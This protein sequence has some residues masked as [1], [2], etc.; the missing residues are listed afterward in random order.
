MLLIWIVFVAPNN[1]AAYEV[2]IGATLLLAVGIL[3]DKGLLHH[4]LKLFVAM[5]LAAF[6]VLWSGRRMQVF[7]QLFGEDAGWIADTTLSFV[8]V[9]GVTAAFSILDHMDGLCA[10]VCAIGSA[11]LFIWATSAGQAAEAVL[12]AGLMGA[13]LGFLWWNFHPAKIFM[14]DGGAMFL[15]FLLAA[16]SLRVEFAGMP[17]KS[18]WMTPTLILIVPVFDTTLVTISRSRRGL[19]PFTSPGKDHTAHRIAGRRGGQRGAVLTLYALGAVGGA[20]SLVL[21]NLD[22]PQ[23]WVL[24]SAT[25]SAVLLAIVFLERLP[26]EKQEPAR[27]PKRAHSAESQPS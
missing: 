7:S 21:P 23:R 25:A 27:I 9:V 2:M 26:F 5:P 16:L 14:G 17:A 13:A 8:W 20:L 4:Q 18:A 1:F 6:L 19:V 3:D 10:G 24:A 22:G 15:G 11:Y 12:A